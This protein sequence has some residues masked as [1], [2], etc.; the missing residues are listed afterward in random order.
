VVHPTALKLNK[1]AKATRNNYMNN[2]KLRAAWRQCVVPGWMSL[3]A[4]DAEFLHLL[5]RD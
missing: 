2:W 3:V 4:T 5:V 1:Y